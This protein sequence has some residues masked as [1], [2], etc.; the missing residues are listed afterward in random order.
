MTPWVTRLLVANVVI[1]VVTMGAPGLVGLLA[2]Q[3]AS[4]LVH[5]WTPLTYMFVHDTSGISHI[6]FNMLSLYFFGP[7]VEARLGGDR[8]IQLYLTSG[9]MGAALSLFTPMAAIVGASGAIFGVMYAFAHFFPHE[10]V[11]VWGV[12]P[13][14]ARLFV[15]VMT[16]ISLFGASGRFEPGVAHYAHLG[17]FVGG[18]LYMRWLGWRAPQAAFRR[19]VERSLQPTG[20]GSDLDRWAGIR[21]EGL[22][23]LNL[24][25][26]D[27]LRAKI[28]AHGVRSL[29]RE[30]RN[31]LDRLSLRTPGPG[32]PGLA[33][34]GPADVA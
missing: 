4:F 5:P 23:P 6:L 25:E 17:G 29:T 10:R 28:G 22:H 14:P 26:L 11:Y 16:A 20:G 27:R 30:E 3:P 8:F 21:R 2:F 33:G 9:L 31:F 34:D 24:E 18:W 1:Y 15:L 7:A 12:L 32:G 13:V 19:K